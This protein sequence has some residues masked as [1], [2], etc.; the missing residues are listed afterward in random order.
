[1]HFTYNSYLYFCHKNLFKSSDKNG[2]VERK[3]FEEKSKRIHVPAC[4]C[5]CVLIWVG[6]EILK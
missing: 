3:T 5:V 1:M 6:R 4:G 2:Y